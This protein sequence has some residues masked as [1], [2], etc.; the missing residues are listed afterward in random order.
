MNRLFGTKKEAPPRPTLA[1]GT[2]VLEKRGES[3]DQKIM[4]LDKEL[5][6]YTTQMKAMKPGPAKNSVQKRAI[7][8]L[9]QK[10]MY[11]AQKEKTM[12]Q[13]FNMEQVMFAQESLAETA[14][15]VTAM[16]DANK[17]LKKQF[18]AVKIS[19]VEDLQ[20]DMA[21]LL[22]QADEIQE[23][24]GRSYNT[25]DV[26]EDDLEAELAALEEDP[27][28]FM[29]AETDASAGADYL[30]LPASSTQPV[31][32]AADGSVMPEASAQPA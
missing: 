6:R 4:K 7:A 10:K 14:N 3:L 30:D 18:K 17:A 23:A 29:S 32:S 5:A 13:Q 26:D 9:K 20:D 12:N 21:D 22:E 25:D 1:D 11:E 27:S 15:T 8:I 31:E 2:G 28:L 19:E 24:M 16:K